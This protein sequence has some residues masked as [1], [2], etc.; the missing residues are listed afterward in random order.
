MY[1]PLPED[2]QRATDKGR[3]NPYKIESAPWG[4]FLQCNWYEEDGKN[5]NNNLNQVR[6]HPEWTSSCPFISISGCKSMNCVLWPSVPFNDDDYDEKG[7]LKPGLLGVKDFSQDL[8][9]VI[10]HITNESRVFP[11]YFPFTPRLRSSKLEVS[12]T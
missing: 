1:P 9:D 11:V 4:V 10:T 5:P 8:H 2:L 7:V 3:I 6:Y 12:G